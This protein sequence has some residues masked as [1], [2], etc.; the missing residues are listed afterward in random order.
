MCVYS[1]ILLSA[2]PTNRYAPKAQPPLN[3]MCNI[4]HTFAIRA[5]SFVCGRPQSAVVT[6]RKNELVRMQSR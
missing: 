5:V 3:H 2:R 6:L 4:E 1:T